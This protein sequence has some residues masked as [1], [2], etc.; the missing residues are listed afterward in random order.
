MMKLETIMVM[1]EGQ[2]VI[3]NV[4]LQLILLIA[5]FWDGCDEWVCYDMAPYIPNGSM[6][7]M[8]LIN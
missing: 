7:H 8:Y 3:F 6:R 1:S 5:W 4:I 2:E